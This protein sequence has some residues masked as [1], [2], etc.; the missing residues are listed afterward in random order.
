MDLYWTSDQKHNSDVSSPADIRSSAYTRMFTW[1]SFSL[2]SRELRWDELA[3]GVSAALSVLS[4]VFF[5]RTDVTQKRLKTQFSAW[6]QFSLSH[7]GKQVRLRFINNLWRRQI[8]SSVL[9]YMTEVEK[10]FD[11]WISN[12]ETPVK[13]PVPWYFPDIW[14][15]YVINNSNRPQS[16]WKNLSFFPKSRLI[17]VSPPI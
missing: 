11:G 14:G 1:V 12:T 16:G 10:L 4:C 5:P 13:P 15:L 7:C 2:D 3:H 17:E 6:N 9:F 8:S